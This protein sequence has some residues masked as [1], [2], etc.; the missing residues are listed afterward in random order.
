MSS[1]LARFFSGITTRIS[2]KLNTH[3]RYFRIYKRIWNER[4]PKTFNEKVL[5]LRYNTY[6][7]N[8]I[9]VQCADKLRVRDYLAENGYGE[10]LVPLIC[11][12][13][14]AD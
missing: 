5:W 9:I 13:E 10:L 1:K 14:D 11:V 4:N 7:N 2:P 12:Y 3:L 6:Q 8:P